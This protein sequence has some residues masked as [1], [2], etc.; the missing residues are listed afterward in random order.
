MSVKGLLVSLDLR[1]EF[2]S[3]PLKLNSAGVNNPDQCGEGD[4]NGASV[5]I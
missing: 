2:Q 3:L 4:T 5:P 1:S